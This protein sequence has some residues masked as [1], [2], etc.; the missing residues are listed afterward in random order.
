MG[1]ACTVCTTKPN[2]SD[3]QT[4]INKSFY[5]LQSLGAL[6]DKGKKKRKTHLINDRNQE[7]GITE[8]I[9]AV[10]T[11][12]TKTQ[13]DVENIL[14]A[15]RG[16]FIFKNLDNESQ[17]AIIDHVKHYAIGPKEVIFKQNDPGES[18]FCVAKGRLE[19]LCNGERS[20]IGPGTGFGE[21]ALLDD[22][23][24]TATIRT[25]EACSL[26]GVDRKT[27]NL[28]IKRLNEMNYS[29]NKSFIN[30]IT[31]FEPLTPNQKEMIVSALVT[32]KWICGQTIIKEGD[33]G[34]LF[35]IIKEGYVICY[36][37]KIEKRQLG[38]GEYFGEQALLYNT[39][40]TATVVAGSDLKVLSIGRET[41][42]QVLGEKFEYILYSNTQLIAID[43]STVLRSLSPLQIGSLLKCSIIKRYKAGE[44]IVR[45]GSC[46]SEKLV[47]I[48]KGCVRGPISDLIVHSC[49]GDKEVSNKDSSDYLIDY[50][51][52]TDTDVAEIIVSEF[53]AELG[54]EI[55]QIAISNEVNS[56]ITRIHLF[57]NLS[58]N[59]SQTL[60]KHLRV[61]HFDDGDSIIKQDSPGDYFY[62]IKSGI[63]KVF[64]NE[65]YIRDITKNDYFGERSIL[66]NTQ[67]TTTIIAIGPVDCWVLPKIAFDE[68]VDDE[69]KK[70][71]IERI[72]MQDTKITLEDLMPIKVIGI[73]MF[74]NVILVK[75]KESKVLYA[76]KSVS[77]NKIQSLDI[78]DNLVLERRIMLQLNNNMIVR[79]LRTFKDWNRIYFLMEYVNGQDLFDVLISMQFVREESA[80]FYAACIVVIIEYLHDRN[81][82]H[83][84][85]KPE[86]IMIDEEGYPKLIDFGTAK[87]I[88]GRTYTTLGTP[89]YMAPEIIIRNGYNS[90]V[91]LWSFGILIYEIIYGKVPF[92]SEDDDPKIIYEKILENKL[93]LRISPY[94]GNSYKSFIQQLLS[95]N[96]AARMGGSIE[97]LKSHSWFANFNWKRLEYKKLKPPFIPFIHPETTRNSLTKSL[98]EFIGE[99]EGLETVSNR[100]VSLVEPND[101]DSE[102]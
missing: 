59:N 21:L 83:R 19:V 25:I 81:I 46:K 69:M 2:T 36:E 38:K 50:I 44:V 49:I 37:N 72:E 51:A 12:K 26:W 70:I 1:T 53:E 28:S 30:S 14:K 31:I 13:E 56:I 94:V 93:D 76:I 80:K 102:F 7:K 20:V 66:F 98:Q 85:L 90:S 58:Q 43:K 62:I 97:K 91:D 84:D 47:I 99:I 5:R 54:G 41:L 45:R 10:I 77:R 6:H 65:V 60:T 40:R 74:G 11:I 22:R 32:Q 42:M 15:L 82:V 75:H 95:I 24:R 64:K 9:T 48:L 34:D 39:P 17:L 16:H 8:A 67:R 3:S 88:S 29:E 71:F 55:N 52:V 96:P 92:G 61:N 78:Y 68:I 79:L 35:Y 101:W 57:H 23:P 87:I 27:F 63:V 89:H 18:F 4:E 86:N 100:R 33:I 73:G